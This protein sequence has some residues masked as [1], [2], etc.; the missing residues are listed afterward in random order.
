MVWQSTRQERRAPLAA[1]SPL[2]QDAEGHRLPSLNRALNTLHVID[3]TDRLAID[4]HKHVALLHA[5]V[6]AERRRLHGADQNSAM[7]L[8]AHLIAA[9]GGKDFNSNAYGH[10]GS[11]RPAGLF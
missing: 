4:L 11:P 2:P 5:D 10:K 1:T 7:L 6:F 3:R 9:G 8:D